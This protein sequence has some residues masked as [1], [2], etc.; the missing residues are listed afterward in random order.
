M[1][2]FLPKEIPA[3][4]WQQLPAQKAY[5]FRANPDETVY[6]RFGQGHG[7]YIAV[8]PAPGGRVVNTVDIETLEQT[9][10]GKI[11]E[12]EDISLGRTSESAIKIMHAIVSRLHLEFR[13]EGNVLTVTDPGSTNGTFYLKGGNYFDI[14]EYLENYPIEQA[15]ER[16]MDSIHEAFGPQLDEF[17]KNY[18]KRKENAQ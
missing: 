13:L 15:Q 4:A 14:D 5:A 1:F 17:L 12:K 2:K 18:L 11:P 10:V 9:V 3:E 16:T 7:V 6:F 8:T